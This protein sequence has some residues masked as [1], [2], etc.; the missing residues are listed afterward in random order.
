ME[1][2]NLIIDVAKCESCHN[3]VLATKDEHCD[4]SFPGYAAPQPKHGHHWIQIHRRV[5]GEVPMVDAA[6]L[7][8]M[9]NQCDDAPCVKASRDGAV[10]KRLDGIV[11]IDPEKAKG[12]REIISTCP[13]GAIWW[14]DEHR[15]AQKWI[16]DAHLLDQG[17]K[18]PR[19]VQACPTGALRA[20]K[21][22]DSAMRELARREGLEWLRP[23][24]GTR[25]R[26]YYRNLYRYTKCFISGGVV[27]DLNNRME[28]IEGAS[29]YLFG[30][31][32]QVAEAITDVFGDFKFDKLEPGSGRYRV[33][34]S[35]SKY[36]SAALEVDL[37]E[38]CYVGQVTLAGAPAPIVLM[39]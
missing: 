10:Y 7:P 28:C 15:V 33:T 19:C 30:E 8:T 23:E 14:N 32:G 37:G 11:I 4:N 35:H 25:P 27:G 18:E 3:C 21:I 17:W 34:A 38:S 1:K 24:F 9:C 20:V 29:V 36:G 26:V 5:R 6:Y 39:A 2:W 22:E 31:N 13:Y 16:F 12:R